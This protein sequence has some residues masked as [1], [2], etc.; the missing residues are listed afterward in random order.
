MREGDTRSRAEADTELAD[1]GIAIGPY[2][3]AQRIGEG[4]MGVVYRARDV[5]T[6]A[7]V[8]V[9][10]LKDKSPDLVR[11]FLR[12]ARIVA[13]LEHPNIVAVH[14]VLEREGEPPAIVMELL[15][16]DSLANRL[17]RSSRLSTEE[18]APIVIAIAQAIHAAHERGVIHRDLKPDNVFLAKTAVK[19]LDFGIA[20]L[21]QADDAIASTNGTL[22]R[23]G[24]LLGTPHY[25]APEVIFGEDDIDARADIWSL[26]V[27]LYQALSGTRPFDGDNAGQVFKAIALDPYVPIATRVPLVP[28][29]VASLIDRMLAHARAERVSDLTEVVR[30]FEPFTG[31]EP[32]VP[33]SRP[34]RSISRRAIVVSCV[35]AMGAIGVFAWVAPRRSASNEGVPTDATS[36]APTSNPI[37]AISVSPTSSVAQLTPSSISTGPASHPPHIR[38]PSQKLP[39]A[40]VAP[41]VTAPPTPRHRSG[42]LRPEE[43]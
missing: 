27:I 6:S 40:S 25:M 28:P 14:D 5:R 43:L 4:G 15:E 41:V 39:S 32:L 26:G 30:V 1:G 11:R 12:E 16:G 33:G 38:A 35:L 7:A 37:P 42:D 31:D 8:A 34:H 2:R 13:S 17:A 19:V 18:V 21:T 29:S 20:K 22:T 9:K 10:I 3:L 36:V 23:T 24:A